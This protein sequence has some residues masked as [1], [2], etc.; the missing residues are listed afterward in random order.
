MK[1]IGKTST[2]IRDPRLFKREGAL[3]RDAMHTVS[4]DQTT[5][6]LDR[7]SSTPP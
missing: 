7:R 3:P 2:Q 4:P 6:W 1:G 5:G